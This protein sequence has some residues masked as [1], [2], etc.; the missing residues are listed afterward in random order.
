MAETWL[1]RVILALPRPAIAGAPGLC[2]P[3]FVSF[4]LVSSF[5]VLGV[6]PKVEAVVSCPHCARCAWAMGG[7]NDS[8]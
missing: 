1:K 5:D 8:L 7:V 2:C 4:G 3:G 6:A